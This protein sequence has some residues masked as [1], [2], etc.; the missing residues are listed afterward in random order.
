[1]KHREYSTPAKFLHW[2]MAMVIF[3]SWGIGYYSSTLSTKEKMQVDS[4]ML[5]KSVATV[6]LF[7]IACRIAWRLFNCAPEPSSGL[8]NI[9]RKAAALGHVGLY[10]CMVALPLSGWLWSSTAGYPIPVANLFFLPPLMAKTPSLSPLFRQVHITLAYSI[11]ILVSGHVTMAIKHHF[12]DGG[13]VI[14]SMLPS[15]LR[16]KDTQ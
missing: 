10:I 7:L 8:S 14:F 11:A 1:M 3:A 15:C 4:I 12:W 6:T 2:A 9:E 13:D 5:H 16:R